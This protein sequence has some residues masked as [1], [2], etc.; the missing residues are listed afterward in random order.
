MAA[1]SSPGRVGYRNPV[2]CD[3]MTKRDKPDGHCWHRI[4]HLEYIVLSCTHPSTP[5]LHNEAL[6]VVNDHLLD[7]A[8]VDVGRVAYAQLLYINEV[9][10]GTRP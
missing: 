3:E 6:R 9:Q 7:H 1:P 4:G 2:A 5:E 10:A 8:L